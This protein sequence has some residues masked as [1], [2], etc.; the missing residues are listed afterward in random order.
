VNGSP[1]IG[2]AYIV[3]DCNDMTQSYE[4]VFKFAEDSGVDFIHFRPLSEATVDRF[5]ADWEQVCIQLEAIAVKHPKVQC[6]PLGKRWKDVIY[7]REF[8]TCYSAFTNAV[9]GA[10]GDVQACCDRRDIVFGNVNQQSF[11]SIWLGTKHREKAEAIQPKLCTRCLQCGYNRAVERF[12]VGNEALP[13]L[14]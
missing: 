13:E 2:I 10:N 8:E 14:L 9:I 7:Q 6:F 11:K 1:E 4:D 12:V 3:A 5:T